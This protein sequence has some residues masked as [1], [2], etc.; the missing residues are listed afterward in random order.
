MER[1]VIIT[2]S[3]LRNVSVEGFW[4]SVYICQS[5]DQKLGVLFFW[6]SVE[7][8]ISTPNDDISEYMSRSK[9]RCKTLQKLCSAA[10]VK[11]EN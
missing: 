10:N 7:S 5:Y 6:D 1:A 3:C 2:Q 8:E 4:K 11:T 9:L